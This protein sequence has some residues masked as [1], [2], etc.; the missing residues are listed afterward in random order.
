M[1]N[2]F[3]TF[4]FLFAA[5]S[6]AA[7]KNN[8]KYN[9]PAEEWAGYSNKT[10]LLMENVDVQ[11]FVNY[12]VMKAD[13]N[14]AEIE[15]FK[16][17]IRG[18]MK[19][20]KSE[21][22]Y[23]VGKG[24]ITKENIKN[25]W[26]TK[27]PEYAVLYKDFLKHKK[28]VIASKNAEEEMKRAGEEDKPHV[29]GCGS[30]C[31]NPSFET[32]TTSF[33]DGSTGTACTAIDPCTPV[34]GF[35]SSQHVITTVGSYDATVGGTILPTVPP[36]GGTNALM[37]GDGPT[38]GANAA[39]VSIS[40]TVDAGS[41][42]FTYRYA[43]VLED[44]VSG[45]TDPQRPYFKVKLRDALGNVLAC[46]DYE[47]I[48]KP[49]IVGFTQIP[50]TNVYYRPWTTVFVPL[51][52]YIG[53]CVTLEFTSSDCSQSGHYGYAYV[54]ADCQ[55]TSLATSSPAVCAGATVTL[56]A[57]AGA[58]AYSW[59]NTG[60]GDSTGIV[61]SDSSQLAYVNTGGT[62]E[63]TMTSVTGAACTTTLT[64]T[65]GS[66]PN[67]PVAAFTNDTVICSS[68][69]TTFTNL[70]TPSDSISVYQWDFDNDGIT[71]DSTQ[72]PIYTFP[73]GGTFPVTL[74]ITWGPCN[75]SVT[76]NVL[77]LPG[78]VPVISPVAPVC[79]NAPNMTLV[80]S[81]SGGFWSGP[82]IIDSVSGL[83]DPDS[84]A[85]G[86]N[87]I[88]Y[89][90]VGPCAEAD[91]ISITVIPSSSPAWTAP[92]S[93]CN[94]APTV[95]LN[96]LITGT[97]GG[98]WSGT[99]VTG[100][101]F[102]PTALSG[103]FAVTYTVGT[104]PCVGTNTQN[105]T[106][107]PRADA[108]ITPVIAM[109]DNGTSVT[110]TAAQPGGA[111]T[112]TGV[113]TTGVFN[114]SSVP[115][116]NYVLT[117]TISGACGDVDTVTVTVLP[118][119]DPSFNPTSMCAT[120]PTINLNSLI[121]GDPGGVWSGPGVTGNTFDP[122]GLNGNVTITYTAGTG[123]CA[124]TSSETIF[125]DGIN[126]S[127]I[128]TPDTG[129]APLTVA[130]INT[131]TGGVSYQWNF[132]NGQTSTSATPDSMIYPDYGTFPVTLIATNSSGCSDTTIV[133]IYVD[134][135]SYLIVPNIFSPNGDNTNDVFSLSSLKL[136]FA[137]IE[138]E[139]SI[140]DRWGLKLFDWTDIRNGWDGKGKNGRPAPD[141]TYF[142]IISAK[143]F[144]GQE[145]KAQ[146][147]LSL[148]R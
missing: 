18:K 79:S 104:A 82:G 111:W 143:G 95:N 81:L 124:Q 136:S 141:G 41:T 44:P 5:L 145:Y 125:V 134:A 74:T 2:L 92:A 116:G 33:W 36:G 71:D 67:N 26:T 110:M 109:C 99:G 3:F 120:A 100:S 68:T 106:V 52:A 137:I 1:K 115:A 77:V 47:V 8:N 25:F 122:D 20:H 135:I 62:Y 91:T 46:G 54:D 108:T 10:N 86:P 22:I 97:P 103:T 6:A 127:F 128:A 30:P 132:G 39:R 107:I 58:A 113:S 42:N 4:L 37:L 139:A 9:V 65:V 83:F 17:Y 130:F 138:F 63:V 56:T 50:G 12:V 75:V 23:K 15:Y 76:Q 7:Q 84:A 121:T 102:D 119:P 57:P 13:G 129:Y 29:L 45:H 98:T 11:S 64:I 114:P 34:L 123:I 69:P 73:A 21:L 94:D 80:T 140:Y 105:L 90:T 28:E 24:E 117:Y 35:S 49:P 16:F 70:S 88:I 96:T 43:V 48:A 55:S 142:Y 87:T 59:V 40:F 118:T 101:I 89:S 148:V 93:M 146:G 51:S 66:S 133:Y 32:G 126:A 27:Q 78:G 147:H 85:S 144:D 38:N 14:F 131:S 60:T 31:T 19:L 61:G 72:N 112:G 53:Q